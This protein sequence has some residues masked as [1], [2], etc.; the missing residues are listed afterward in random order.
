MEI[1]FC[2]IRLSQC[3]LSYA[4]IEFS[5]RRAKYLIILLKINKRHDHLFRLIYQTGSSQCFDVQHL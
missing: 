5:D 1:F 2:P 4:S 3:V